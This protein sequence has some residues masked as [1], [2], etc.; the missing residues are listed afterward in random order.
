MMR[1]SYNTEYSLDKLTHRNRSSPS[2]RI[3]C[4]NIRNIHVSN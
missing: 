3:S 2:N 4:I 1:L